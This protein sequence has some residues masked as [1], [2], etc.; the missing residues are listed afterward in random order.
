MN[1]G[2]YSCDSGGEGGGGGQ[3]DG[4]RAQSLKYTLFKSWTQFTTCGCKRKVFGKQT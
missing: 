2:V 3:G 1:P 4:A